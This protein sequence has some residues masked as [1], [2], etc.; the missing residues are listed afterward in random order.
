MVLANRFSARGGALP[1]EAELMLEFGTTRNVVREALGL[2]RDEGLVERL[3]GAGTFVVTEKIL[4][5][6]DVLRGV[7]DGFP[8]RRHRMRG[9]VPTIARIAAPE[10]VAEQLG[11]TVGEE[12]L[13]VDAWVAFDDVPFSLATSYLPATLED[14]LRGATFNGDWYE[15]LESIGLGLETSSMSVEATVADDVVGPWLGVAIGA[16]LVLF[17]R[18]IIGAD[19]K[20][21]EYGFVRVRADRVLLQIP[22]PRSAPAGREPHEDTP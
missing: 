20:P 17:T 8:N 7:G 1:S 10:P 18:L 21:V 15:L 11:L 4:H 13:R 12:C 5:R 22:L 9:E 3:Q 19:G 6:F 16:P 2:L 14:A